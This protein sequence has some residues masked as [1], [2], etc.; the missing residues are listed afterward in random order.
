MMFNDHSSHRRTPP[1]VKFLFFLAM[2]ALVLFVLGHLVMFLWNGILVE[3]TGVK[4]LNFWQSLGLLLLSRILVGGLRFG[5]SRG[6]W[7]AS[8]RR[9]WKEKWTHMSEEERA[10][11]RAKWKERC[12][13]K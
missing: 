1:P 7:N 11:F 4:A 5:P 3:A 12:E 2:G 8:P 10:A 13:R 9:H 6:P